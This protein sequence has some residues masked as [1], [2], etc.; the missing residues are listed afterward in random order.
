M[1]NLVEVSLILIAIVSVVGVVW[2]MRKMANGISEGYTYSTAYD[3]DGNE[4]EVVHYVGEQ[5]DEEK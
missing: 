3:E 1:Y 4:I 2:F 5:N